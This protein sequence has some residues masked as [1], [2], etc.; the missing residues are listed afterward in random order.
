MKQRTYGL[1]ALFLAASV[2]LSA[3]PADSTKAD[4]V[5]I[6]KKNKELPLEPGRTVSFKTQN[7]TWMSVDISPDGKTLL[8]DLM[9]DIYQ[10]PFGGGKAEAVT[11]GMAW[12]VHPRFSPDG[13]S[14]V[15]VSDRSGA[16]AA[17]IYDFT[18]KE[19]TQL[20]KDEDNYVTSAEWSTDGNYVFV[21]KG[22][23]IHK[24]YMY[25]REGGRGAQLINDP[26]PLKVI[27]PAVGP[28]GRFVYFSRR[29]GAWNYNAQLPQ[30]Q[31]GV[32]DLENAT[33]T[34]ISNKYGSAFTPT[35]SPDGKW[36]VYG[37]RY[38]EKTGLIARELATGAEKWIA[39]PVQR[40]EQESIAPLGVLPGMTF[41]PDSKEVLATWAGK[42]WRIPV[43]GGKA[44]EIPFSVDVN[45]QLGPEVFFKY[46][47]SDAQKDTVTQ[48]RDAVPSPDGKKLAFTAL[49]RLYVMDLPKGTPARVT[50]MELTEAM[51]SWSPDSK[52]LVFSTWSAEEN[53]HLYKVAIGGKKQAKAV[54]LT[55]IPAIYL[56]P[57]WTYTNRILFLRAPAQ[58]Y[59]EDSGPFAAFGYV[60]DLAWIGENGG[61]IT[62]VDKARG[63]DNPHVQKGVDRI[64]LNQNGTL[65]SIRW[66]GTDLKQ[67][68]KVTGIT[69]YGSN[70]EDDHF[71]KFEHGLLSENYDVKENNPPT[72]ASQINMAPSGNEALVQVNNDIY[73]VTVPKTGKVVNIS[74]ANAPSSEFPARQLTTIGGQFPAW[75]GDGKKVHWSIGKAHFMFDLDKA[76]A[77]DDSVKAAKKAEKEKEEKEKADKAKG[78]KTDSAKTD[79]AKTDSAKTAA[80]KKDEKKIEPKFEAEEILVPV[81]FDRD[82]PKGLILLSGARLVTMNGKEVIE[83]GDILIENNRIKAYGASGTL[84]VPEGTKT[85]DV[86]GKTIVPGFVDTHAHM[87]PA[88]GLH[89]AQEWTY[90]ANLAYGVTTTRDPQT[91]T[92]D[93]L[94]YSDLVEAGKMLGPRIYST[95]PGIGFWS[96][97]LKD[98]DHARRVMKQYSRYYNTKTIKMYLVG[99]RKQRQWVIQAAKE[100]KIMPT[101]EGGLDFKLN[102]TQLLDGYPGHEHALPIYPL[103]DDVVTTI[104]KAQMAVTPT[105]LVSYGGPWAENYFYS[106]ENPYGD[107]KLARFTPYDELAPKSRRR[108]G[109]FRD[110]EHVFPKH[111]ESMKKLVEGGS[112]AGIGSHGQLQGLGF[113]WE[114]WSM[115]S[116]GMSTHDALRTATILGAT[117]IGLD[118]DLGSI[119]SGKLAD[120]VIMDK[121][122]LE[123][124]RNSNTV[125]FVVKNGRVYDAATLDEIAPNARKAGDLG[126][127]NNAPEG[128]PGDG[129]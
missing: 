82:I 119:S 109:W 51:P 25:H 123:N 12:D 96:Y 8:F 111:A 128:T 31:L 72:P 6:E 49:N 39:Y 58:A 92:T 14:M 60:D 101:T 15:F 22:R 59:K 78:V 100:Q 75:S 129:R 99:N 57:V 69:T 44:V 88:W 10:M 102:M 1:A 3:M 74:V 117:A 55:K 37:S 29:N 79:A 42:F 35:L 65:L 98:L 106:R 62:V 104:S 103:F 54:K 81:L 30:Y 95:G 24:L 13:K 121:N 4:S 70:P 124:I 80:P 77:F 108:P 28:E 122:P 46:P 61:A 97:N 17:W 20:T 45:L 40:D 41:T 18:S 110:E 33:N 105:L 34:V 47:V 67:H 2:P 19:Y 50:D 64:F 63:R 87:W 93:V 94:T 112:L 89:K 27:D 114:L 116:G 113:H 48:I 66:D 16:D 5:K 43:T 36:L 53:G 71:N 107:K 11:E 23:R 7:G 126:V 73:V 125:V 120:L 68:V 56:T 26:A 52:N 38:E 90:A 91:G 32:Y 9:G 21:S 84:T 86:S 83:R 127:Y 115:A 85:I 76:K 118:N